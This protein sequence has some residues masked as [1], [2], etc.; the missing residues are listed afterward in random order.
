MGVV[1]LLLLAELVAEIAVAGLATSFKTEVTRLSSY[2]PGFND[3]VAY[4]S[5]SLLGPVGGNVR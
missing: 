2:L 5:S 1:E 3:C 4:A